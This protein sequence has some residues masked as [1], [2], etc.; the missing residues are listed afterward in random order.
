ME[1]VSKREIIAKACGMEIDD[2]NR[3]VMMKKLSGKTITQIERDLEQ[4]AWA[5]KQPLVFVKD[6]G[7]N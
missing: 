1:A 4:I 3:L 5:R 7:T 6:S 2:L